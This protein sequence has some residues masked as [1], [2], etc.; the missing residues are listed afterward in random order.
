MSIIDCCMI[1]FSI[2]SLFSEFITFRWMQSCLVTFVSQPV[3]LHESYIASARTVGT[4]GME[5]CLAWLA[6]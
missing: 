2:Q 4:A 3:V 1:I 6:G 5:W